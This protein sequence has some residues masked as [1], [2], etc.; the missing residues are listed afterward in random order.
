MASASSHIARESVIPINE[1]KSKS[2]KSSSRRRH[3]RTK[4]YRITDYNQDNRCIGIFNKQR[5]E[6]LQQIQKLEHKLHA[7]AAEHTKMNRSRIN[8]IK[9]HEEDIKLLS[10][11]NQRLYGETEILKKHIQQIKDKQKKEYF[12][13]EES[14]EIEKARRFI[15]V[16][17]HRETLKQISSLKAQVSQSRKRQKMHWHDIHQL[18]TELSQI[19]L[20]SCTE[21]MGEQ[22]DQSVDSSMIMSETTMSNRDEAKRSSSGTDTS[23]Q[24][25]R[26]FKKTLSPSS[27]MAPSKVM[28]QTKE[29]TRTYDATKP[30]TKINILR[31]SG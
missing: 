25:S 18:S 26:S 3:R 24:S 2:I 19:R 7:F 27:G 4:N 21:N 16:E 15:Q 13:L 29:L 28:I 12:E 14:V 20:V 6:F 10:A 5:D 17:R 31:E 9:N 11:D 30:K 23:S 22:I 8:R 1:S